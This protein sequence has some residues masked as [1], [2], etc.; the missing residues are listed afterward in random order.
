MVEVNY[1]INYLVDLSFNWN[2]CELLL[3]NELFNGFMKK[4]F[5]KITG[6]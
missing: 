4:L 6:F 5:G 3:F 1:V 2:A